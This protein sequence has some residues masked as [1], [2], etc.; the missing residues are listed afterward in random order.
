MTTGPYG[1]GDTACQNPTSVPPPDKVPI[2]DTATPTIPHG[3]A[4]G[5]VVT[6]MVPPLFVQSGI[7]AG[8]I[9]SHWQGAAR[10]RLLALLGSARPRVGGHGGAVR[11]NHCRRK[12]MWTVRHPGL[13]GGISRH[14][15][16]PSP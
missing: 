9:L 7:G 15:G 11:G 6:V 10:R 12:L 14:R 13:R 1:K 5:H 16:G 4:D 8:A 2:C 3:S